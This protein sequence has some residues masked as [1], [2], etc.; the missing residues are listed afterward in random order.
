MRATAA[1]AVIGTTIVTAGALAFACT[2]ATYF[3]LSPDRGPAGSIVTVTAGETS[4]PG[5]VTIRWNGTDGPVLATTN[6]PS[7][8]VRVRIPADA[9]LGVGTVVAVQEGASV[10]RDAFEVTPGTYSDTN[11]E[12]PQL[13]GSP[14]RSSTGG[15]TLGAGRSSGPANTSDAT[16]DEGEEPVTAV[17]GSPGRSDPAA[18]RQNGAEG[19]RGD[20]PGISAIAHA[21]PATTD[22]LATARAGDSGATTGSRTALTSVPQGAGADNVPAADPSGP[23]ALVDAAGTPSSRTS[24]ADL[25]GG[26]AAGAIAGPS[27]DGNS[28]SADASWSIGAAMAI[29]IAGLLAMLAGFAVA[30]VRRRRVRATAT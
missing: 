26:F 6:G 17:G 28:R 18:T 19:R 7:F 16:N 27:L 4:A 23:L 3:T 21:Q 13:T 14:Q 2:T 12:D 9:E 29:A 8:S 25:W 24:A 10:G 15:S 20:G 1:L 22:G 5:P 11:A 30:E